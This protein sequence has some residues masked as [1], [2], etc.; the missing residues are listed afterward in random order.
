MKL[1][2][3]WT[4]WIENKFNQITENVLETLIKNQ[5]R[6]QWVEYMLGWIC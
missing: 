4:D 3:S 5:Y 6:V 1:K 2:V